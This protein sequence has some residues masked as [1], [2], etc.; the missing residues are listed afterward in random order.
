MPLPLFHQKMLLM[1][2]CASVVVEAHTDFFFLQPQFLTDNFFT[3]TLTILLI[4]A[5]LKISIKIHLFA[6]SLAPLLSLGGELPT[7][8]QSRSPFR[9]LHVFLIYF[10]RWGISYLLGWG[11]FLGGELR[12][13]GQF[14]T[15]HR[16]RP[17][18]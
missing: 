3:C 15:L 9:Q 1:Q 12:R 16:S 17:L 4:L 6:A 2:T 5:V 10:S 11:I 7:L 8:Y 18:F 13:I 14:S